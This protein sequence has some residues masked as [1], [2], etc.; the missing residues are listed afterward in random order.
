M[1]IGLIF[2]IFAFYAGMKVKGALILV[3]EARNVKYVEQVVKQMLD[4]DN[5]YKLV[6]FEAGKK[7]KQKEEEADPD[8]LE[9]MRYKKMY[10]K[11][12][13]EGE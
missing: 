11:I 1:L 5:P 4:K 2:A 8:Y 3:K 13:Q 12:V 6:N 9:Y 7:A 10:E